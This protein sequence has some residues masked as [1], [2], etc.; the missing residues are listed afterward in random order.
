MAIYFHRATIVGV[1]ANAVAVPLTGVL[2]TTAALAIA[3]SY[4]W[5]PLALVPAKIAG[6]SLAAVVATARLFDGLRLADVRLPMPTTTATVS[7]VVAL[8]TALLLIRRRTF[9]A[10][11]GLVLLAVVSTWLALP[12]AHPQ[13]HPGVLEVTSIDVG[14]AESTLLVTPS[15]ATVLVDA[16]GPLGPFSTNFDFGE[17]VVG[18]YLWARG[19][20][21]LDALALTHAHSDHMGGMPG[22]IANFH[23]RQFWLGPNA[24]TPEL[25]RVIASAR[26]HQVDVQLRHAGENVEFGGARFE[27][28]SPPPGWEVKDKPRNNDSLALRVSYGETSV[29]LTGDAERKIEQYLAQL[30]P[31]A[32][33]LKLA[34]NGSRTS[35]IPEFLAAVQPRFAFISVG[36]QNSFGH[37]RREV[38]ERVQAAHVA[39]YRTDT[40]GAL[41]FL[42]D[43]T[44]V[45]AHAAVIH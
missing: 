24:A 9:L 18:P 8:I 33:V 6:W 41:T 27:V 31:R 23:P 2:V 35:S 32:T 3:L 17:N 22:I 29:L 1:P 11:C 10:L 28:L 26:Q 40:G 21:R 39:T 13:Y 42:L 30:R 34:H 37:P 12:I 25:A 43:G 45:Q 5:L 19:F 15:G 36:A 4:V 20:T 7:G 16:A 38:L 44:G 14:Q